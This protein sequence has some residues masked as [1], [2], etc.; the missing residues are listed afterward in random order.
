[1]YVCVGGCVPVCLSVLQVSWFPLVGGGPQVDGGVLS[2]I[3][4]TSF[5][6]PG[7]LGCFYLFTVVGL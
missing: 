4:G 6:A 1:M 5:P 7:V 2:W 3:S